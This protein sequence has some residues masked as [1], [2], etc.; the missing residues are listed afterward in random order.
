VPRYTLY[1]TDAE[2]DDRDVAEE[3]RSAGGRVIAVKPGLALIDASDRAVARLRTALPEWRI[4]EEH[5]AKVPKP[6]AKARQA[7]R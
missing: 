3:V 2:H 5:T 1:R 7:R 4:T 6:K